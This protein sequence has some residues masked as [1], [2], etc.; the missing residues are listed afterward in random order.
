MILTCWLARSTWSLLENSGFSV[1]GLVRPDPSGGV[2][3]SFLT[4]R[5]RTMVL[6][7][8]PASGGGQ[9]YG[10]RRNMTV[11]GSRDSGS[12]WQPMDEIYTGA[13]GY[14][15][16]GELASGVVALVY[17]REVAGCL[18]GSCSIQYTTL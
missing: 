5:N 17:E 2:Q 4:T 7:A 8:L 1:G 6:N 9:G 11:F 3:E 14:S 13:V 12:S 18:G 15:D 10:H 16:L